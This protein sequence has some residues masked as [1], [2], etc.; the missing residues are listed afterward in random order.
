MKLGEIKKKAAELGVES[1]GLKKAELILKVQKAEG[2]NPC[3]GQND[4]NC[5]Y[6]DCCFWKDCKTESKKKK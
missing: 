5:P 6:S 3:F 2:N 1:K 4:G